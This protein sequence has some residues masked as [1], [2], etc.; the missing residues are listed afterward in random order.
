MRESAAT[1]KKAT[2]PIGVAEYQLTQAIPP[3]FQGSLP[4]IEQLEAELQNDLQPEDPN[5][6]QD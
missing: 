3:E 5:R 4:T 6:E 1:T 2:Q